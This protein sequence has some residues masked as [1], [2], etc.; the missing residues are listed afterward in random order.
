MDLDSL[1]K[2]RRFP[3]SLPVCQQTSGGRQNQRLFHT[4]VVC[5][6]LGI[7]IHHGSQF[8]KAGAPFQF[9]P[10]QRVLDISQP[11]VT[12]SMLGLQFRK[13]VVKFIRPIP[14]RREQERSSLGWCT[15]WGYS[16]M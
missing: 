7:R 11:H 15:C 13:D 6:E 2:R 3:P 8:P 10:G 9:I 4:P 5:M 12:L 1:Q 16:R 14:Q